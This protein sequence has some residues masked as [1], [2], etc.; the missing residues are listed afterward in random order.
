[1]GQTQATKLGNV[2]AGVGAPVQVLVAVVGKGEVMGTAAAI[3]AARRALAAVLNFIL[4]SLDQFGWRW[5]LVPNKETGRGSG[6]RV[7]FSM[8]EVWEWKRERESG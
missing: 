1:M 5:W 7:V 8:K 3:A 4:A 6:F 2:V